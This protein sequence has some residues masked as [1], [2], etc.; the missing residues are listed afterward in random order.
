MTKS[1]WH[2]YDKSSKWLIEHHGDSILR[3]AGVQDI[4]SWHPLPAEIVQPH[5]LPDGLL[6]VQLAGQAEPDLF[7]LE[8]ATYPEPRLSEQIFRDLSL[9]YLDRR[10]L[11]EVFAIIFSPRGNYRAADGLDLRSKHGLTQWQAH[12]RVVELWTLPAE[13]LLAAQDVG[14]IPWIPLTNFPEPPETILRQCRE[15]I[16]LQARAEERQNLLVV[17]GVLASLRYNDPQLLAIF[18]GKGTMLEF[19]IIQE[20]VAE[21]RQ[22]D[23]LTF[24]KARFG[25]VPQDL[26]AEF[27]AI[28]DQQKLQRLA[29]QAGICPDLNSFRAQMRL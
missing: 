11:P 4:V 18:G 15:R 16:D 7:I 1:D 14:L 9:V 23:I 6:E 26:V 10:V 19:P 20:I 2:Q 5:Q 29:E 21:T 25:P 24:L 3:L 12:W 17:T 8:L 13:T 28:V 27:Q 22:E